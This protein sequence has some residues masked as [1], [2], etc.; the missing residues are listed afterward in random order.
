MYISKTSSHFFKNP[1]FLWLISFFVTLLCL[2]IMC[3]FLITQM[4]EQSWVINVN[5]FKES[6]GLAIIFFVFSTFFV[7]I[8]FAWKDFLDSEGYF[9]YFAVSVISIIVLCM[10]TFIISSKIVEYLLTPS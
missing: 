9:S 6:L 5:W 7:Y 8:Q 10:P 3:Y 2:I 4:L 1:I